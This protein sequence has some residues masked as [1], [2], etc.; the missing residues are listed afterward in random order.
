MDQKLKV[1]LAALLPA[2]PL[3]LS[4][5]LAPPPTPLS[6]R[7]QLRRPAMSP[8]VWLASRKL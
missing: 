1:L 8:R 7:R 3:A 5:A 2:G 6:S 4:A